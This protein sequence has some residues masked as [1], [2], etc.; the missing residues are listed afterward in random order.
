MESQ[1]QTEVKVT[2]VL[3]REEATFLNG[4]M[5]NTM[6]RVPE[7]EPESEKTM[8]IAFFNATKLPNKIGF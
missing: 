8:R 7:N 1:I 4:I 6:H 5:Q 3:N 2:L